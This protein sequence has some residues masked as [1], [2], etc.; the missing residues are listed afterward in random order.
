MPDGPAYRPDLSGPDK[1]F[2]DD[3]GDVADRLGLTPSAIR[4]P[5]CEWGDGCLEFA[6]TS[7]NAAVA[8]FVPGQPVPG[9]SSP[10]WPGLTFAATVRADAAGF[11]PMAMCGGQDWWELRLHGGSGV[12]AWSHGGDN[13]I[14]AGG[15]SIVGTG[16]RRLVGTADGSWMRLYVDGVQAQEVPSSALPPTSGTPLLMGERQYGGYPWHGGISDVQVFPRALSAGEVALDA[17][18]PEWWSSSGGGSSSTGRRTPGGPAFR[19]A[20]GTLHPV[21]FLLRDLSGAPAVG[22]SVSVRIAKDAGDWED[23]QG[24]VVE[25]GHGWYSLLGAAPDRESAGDLLVHAEAAGCRPVDLIVPLSE[26][27][28]HSAIALPAAERSAIADAV[29][30]RTW[31]GLATPARSA[32]NALRFLRNARDIDPNNTATVRAEDG[33]AQAWKAKAFGAAGAEPARGQ[34]PA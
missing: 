25:A 5:G 20:G 19:Q 17:I 26:A 1:T 6:G 16:W 8:S 13:A 22:K 3:P 23:A 24:A 30:A 11:Y 34:S 18:D 31:A 9:V 32:L 4:S 29:L 33:S 15:T 12:P 21:S 2:P 27:D 28:L 7:G 10:T 14:D